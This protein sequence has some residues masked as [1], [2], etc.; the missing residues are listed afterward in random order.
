MTQY[1]DHL[2]VAMYKAIIQTQN[3]LVEKN[4]PICFRLLGRY[5]TPKS[6]G[7]LMIQAIKCELASFYS[8]TQ[9]GAIR[10]FGYV[11]SG[12]IELLQSG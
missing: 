10:S 1:L 7:S 9:P 3:K 4:I 6:Y 11:F 12:S 2:F 8:Y 5:V